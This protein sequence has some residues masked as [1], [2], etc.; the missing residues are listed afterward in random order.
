M[1]DG[2]SLVI[3]FNKDNYACYSCH[4]H[5]G[6]VALRCKFHSCLHLN[7][8]I[9]QMLLSKATYIAFQGTH[10]TFLLVLSS[11]FPWESNP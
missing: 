5:Q 6:V 3:H 9:W 1:Q 10:F 7:V 4:E 11:C 2:N 8:C